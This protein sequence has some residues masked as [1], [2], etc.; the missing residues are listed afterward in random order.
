LSAPRPRHVLI[1][2][3]VAALSLA[4]VCALAIDNWTLKSGQPL[5]SD[6]LVGVGLAYMGIAGFYVALG[7]Q[8][9]L[10]RILVSTALSVAGGYAAACGED[11]NPRLWAGVAMF[12]SFFVAVP[13]IYAWARSLRIVHPDHPAP[14][15]WEPRRQFSLWGLLST[16]TVLAIVLGVAVRLQFPMAALEMVLVLCGTTTLI[17]YTTAATLLSRLTW[18]SPVA[19]AGAALASVALLTFKEVETEEA[20]AALFAQ[21]TVT[22]IFFGVLRIAGYRI[23]WPDYTGLETIGP[24]KT[25]S[26]PGEPSAASST[27]GHD[28]DQPEMS[29][30]HAAAAGTI[31]QE[32][33][34]SNH[35]SEQSNLG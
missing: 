21:T 32:A 12:C 15:F 34:Q 20:A 9:V 19:L 2:L 1:A 3:L 25:P 23:R 24:N 11:L 18:V 27:S 16:V 31:L 7:R 35:S 33:A 10:L 17:T 13:G 30:L 29:P 5:L 14:V 22:V 8:P 4:T 6:G 26:L 28:A